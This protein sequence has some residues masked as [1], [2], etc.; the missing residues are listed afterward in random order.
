MAGLGIY[1][2]YQRIKNEQELMNPDVTPAPQGDTLQKK[3]TPED[4]QRY[5]ELRKIIAD[6]QSQLKN[7][8]NG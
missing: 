4:K 6:K 1:R 7:E 5:E 2:T 8:N 3:F